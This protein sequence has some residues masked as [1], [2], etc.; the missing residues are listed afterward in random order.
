[1]PRQAGETGA[2]PLHVSLVA[3]PEDAHVTAMALQ[4]GDES[5]DSQKCSQRNSA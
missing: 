5:M 1:M 2:E 3:I 4:L